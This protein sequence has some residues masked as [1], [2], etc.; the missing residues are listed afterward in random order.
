MPG[1]SVSGKTVVVTGASSGIG[2]ATAV[3]LGRMGADVLITA[4]DAGRGG[5]DRDSDR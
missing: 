4:R 1:A 3:A 5:V 2:L